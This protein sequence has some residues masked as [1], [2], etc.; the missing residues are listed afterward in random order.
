MLQWRGR[1]FLGD[2][3]KVK[4]YL[5]PNYAADGFPVTLPIWVLLSFGSFRRPFSWRTLCWEASTSGQTRK[6]SLPL[7]REL[8]KRTK[9]A[10]E[11]LQWW[12]KNPKCNLKQWNSCDGPQRLKLHLPHE[13]SNCTKAWTNI[14]GYEHT[15]LQ[16]SH[17]QVFLKDNETTQTT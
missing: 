5:L 2:G 12:E 7:R 11:N 10:Q 14:P 13:W 17:H 16:Q 9:N 4:F 8:K 15:T 1:L 6:S 3:R